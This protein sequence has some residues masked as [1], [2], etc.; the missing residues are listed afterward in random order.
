MIKNNSDE[1][2]SAQRTT[3]IVF[4]L[5]ACAMKMGFDIRAAKE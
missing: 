4:T 1:A 3:V 5:Q 2:E